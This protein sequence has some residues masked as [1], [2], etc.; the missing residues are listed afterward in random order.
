VYLGVKNVFRDSSLEEQ[1]LLSN[2]LSRVELLGALAVE[3][4]SVPLANL[5]W[6][7]RMQVKN[8]DKQ[9]ACNTTQH[10]TCPTVDFGN[11]PFLLTVQCR[12]AHFLLKLTKSGEG[13]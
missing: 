3:A 7:Y 9:K 13:V 11:T 5:N 1:C 10:H 4:D 12:L 6:P 8:G 2:G